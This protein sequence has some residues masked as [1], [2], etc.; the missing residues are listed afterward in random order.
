MEFTA[1][2]LNDIDLF[3]TLTIETIFACAMDQDRASVALDDAAFYGPL[4][5]MIAE[6]CAN[7]GVDI[8]Y[9]VHVTDP[10]GEERI[11]ECVDPTDGVEREYWMKGIDEK[12]L[13]LKETQ[14]EQA[15]DEYEEAEND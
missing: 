2:Q 10:D 4:C 1:Q 8:R 3:Q 13:Q 11:Q 15:E 14:H 9:P 6:Y 5:D 12:I 7:H